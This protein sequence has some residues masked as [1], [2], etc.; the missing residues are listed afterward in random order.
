MNITAIGRASHAESAPLHHTQHDKALRLA[1][2]KDKLAHWRDTWQPSTK[3][4]I[5]AQI[6]Q[7]EA[8][9]AGSAT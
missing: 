8:E 4:A 9:L 1:R 7:L 5:E 2:L 6:A 3:A